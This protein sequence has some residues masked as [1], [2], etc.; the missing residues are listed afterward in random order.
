[1]RLKKYNFTEVLQKLRRYCAYQERSHQEVK[2]KLYEWGFDA[3]DSAKVIV[4]LMEESLL[5]E[6][7]FAKAV[8]GGKFRQ[9]GWGRRK[10]TQSLKAKGINEKLIA[11]SLKEIDTEAYEKK[12][13]VLL[14]KKMDTLKGEH[15]LGKK[16]KLSRFGISKGYEPELVYKI[17]Q[18]LL[19]E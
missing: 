17:I 8:A 2:R 18:Q 4:Q 7:R 9:K 10:I 15:Y 5:N 16:Q 13:S 11:A 6:E 3:D 1:M 14:E 12:L 19:S